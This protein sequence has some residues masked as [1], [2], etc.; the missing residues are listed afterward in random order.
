MCNNFIKNGLI[1]LLVRK[2]TTVNDVE[3]KCNFPEGFCT[4]LIAGVHQASEKEIAKMFSLFEQGEGPREIVV[5]IEILFQYLN[6][7]FTINKNINGTTTVHQFKGFFHKK[8]IIVEDSDSIIDQ[9]DVIFYHQADGRLKRYNISIKPY[10][11]SENNKVY[12]FLNTSKRNQ[13]LTKILIILAPILVWIFLLIAGNVGN[14]AIDASYQKMTTAIKNIFPRKEHDLVN[15]LNIPIR[16]NTA[17]EALAL[18]N[19]NNHI[20]NIKLI[21]RNENNTLAFYLLMDNIEKDI[22]NYD[23]TIKTNIIADLQGKAVKKQDLLKH[24]LDNK[25]TLFNEIENSFK[26]NDPIMKLR[27]EEYQFFLQAYET[28]LRVEPAMLYLDEF[29]PIYNTFKTVATSSAMTQEEISAKAFATPIHN[30]FDKTLTEVWGKKRDGIYFLNNESF[31]KTELEIELSIDALRESIG[32]Q[33]TV[34]REFLKQY[35]YIYAQKYLDDLYDNFNKALIA[36]IEMISSDLTVEHVNQTFEDCLDSLI[37]PDII[38]AESIY[39]TMIINTLTEEWEL[40]I[41]GANNKFYSATTAFTIDGTHIFA[42]DKKTPITSTLIIGPCT[43]GE[44]AIYDELPKIMFLITSVPIWSDIDA[45]KIYKY[46]KDNFQLEEIAHVRRKKDD[47]FRNTQHEVGFIGVDVTKSKILFGSDNQRE[48][49]LTFIYD[50]RD[51]DKISKGNHIV[52][53]IEFF[54]KKNVR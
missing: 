44:R 46:I 31:L 50:T 37:L 47:L 7:T 16:A 11:I 51:P 48:V 25:N 43:E 19:Q 3:K 32:S 18:L 14:R 9:G 35:N 22:L 41:W 40:R 49:I 12:L 38:K 1:N 39:K 24:Y 52:I 33:G 54:D 5:I 34:M 28:I 2:K 6:K 53:I 23:L 17:N 21:N 26:I 20:K 8:G 27:N 10:Q 13:R 29:I 15:I 45:S 42:L 36:Q 30:Y 4:R